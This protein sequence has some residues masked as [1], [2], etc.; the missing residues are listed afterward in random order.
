LDEEPKLKIARFIKGLSLGNLI[1]EGLPSN[2]KGTSKDT[3]CYV[4]K[5]KGAHRT[6]A[7]DQSGSFVRNAIAI[8]F[9]EE[10][11]KETL[12]PRSK[13]GPNSRST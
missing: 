4:T 1:H 12:S 9:K 13:H 8:I 6:K 10:Q 3:I 5:T 11:N 7:K 2:L